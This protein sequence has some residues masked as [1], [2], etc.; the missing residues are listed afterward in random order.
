M[1]CS[2]A[3]RF[4]R[5]KVAALNPWVSTIALTLLTLFILSGSD[6]LAPSLGATISTQVPLVAAAQGGSITDQA[7]WS[8]R[9]VT[10]YTIAA[11]SRDSSQ[12]S[13]GDW[14]RTRRGRDLGRPEVPWACSA[15]FSEAI[16]MPRLEY[17]RTDLLLTVGSGKG[18][19]VEVEA[20]FGGIQRTLSVRR[21]TSVPDGRFLQRPLGGAVE[22]WANAARKAQRDTDIASV[23]LRIEEG[24]KLDGEP[25]ESLV[26]SLVD[27]FRPPGYAIVR[28]TPV[29][30]NAP[31]HPWTL[32]LR[33][34]HE[35]SPIPTGFMRRAVDSV[36]GLQRE[37]VR[38]LELSSPELSF[39]WK[40]S[41]D[42][43]TADV[44]HVGPMHTHRVNMPQLP[45]FNRGEEF[46][47]PRTLNRFAWLTDS[48][49]TRLL[50]VD[51]LDADDNE[52]LTR[53]IAA[54]LVARGGP[55]VLVLRH[56]PDDAV[57]ALYDFLIHDRPLDWIAR[58]LQGR[59]SLHD[60]PVSVT[61]VAGAGR[62]EAVRV[63]G[64]GA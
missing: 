9:D 7:F 10:R 38:V 55:A 4:R 57:V 43:P 50:V 47:L 23:V 25:W 51:A 18:G 29:P 46:S 54:G 59:G 2:R 42:W 63:S 31:A 21:F 34:V 37:M 3:S 40:P 64:P 1:R 53:E 30:P 15:S 45:L 24:R 14:S 5:M 35:D 20:A 26:P 52:A 27:S 36:V 19:H 60:V 61:L 16:P 32:P 56:A 13:L 44:L 6:L 39:F 8:R 49:Q 17:T 48:A 62:E 58:E 12:P 41:Q 11:A 33:I 22:A 28:V